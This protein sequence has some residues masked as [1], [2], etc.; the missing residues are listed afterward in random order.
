MEMLNKE[1]LHRERNDA[2]KENRA[3]QKETQQA[4]VETQHKALLILLLEAQ[5]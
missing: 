5:Q 1:I 4:L 3:V 2:K